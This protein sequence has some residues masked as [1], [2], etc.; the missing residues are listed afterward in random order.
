[1]KCASEFARTLL[2]NARSM[3]KKTTSLWDATAPAPR[4]E[5]VTAGVH[6]DVAIIGGG[7]TGLTAAILLKTRGKR[8]A[9]IE[10]G[11]IGAG[12]TGRTT[13]HL[14]EAIDRR[15]HSIART[16]SKDAARLVAE[17]S[18]ASIEHIASNIRE[19][20]IDC[21]FRRVPGFLYTE[22]RSYV[23]EVKQEARAA[24]EAGLR[25]KFV[26]EVPLPFPVRGAVL[27]EDQAQF[28]PGEYI[29]GLAARVPGDGS[30]IFDETHVVDITE[31]EPC[32]IETSGGK[33]TADS[34]FQA[35]NV[36][37]KGFTTL[38]TRDAAYRTYALAYRAS[39]N[40]PDGLFWDTADPYHYTRWQETDGGTF[41]I[42]GGAD[43]KTGHEHDTEKCYESVNQ[44]A[45]EHFGPGSIE[46]RWS[47]QVI[48][49]VDGLPFIG[50]SGKMFVST[51][52]SGQGMTFGTL[53]A[54]IVA[55]R[56]A[57]RANKFADLFDEK[58]IHVRG[59]LKEFV[60]ENVDFPARIV[61][62]RIAQRDVE[63][64]TTDA[65]KAGEGKILSVGGK[66]IAAYRD[67]SGR[68]S[69]ISPVCTHMKCDVAW[70]SAERSWDCP[71]HGSRFGVDGRVLNGPARDPLEKIELPKD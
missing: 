53:G 29:R 12:E 39:G 9:V 44:F 13:A 22:K 31:G 47:G 21:R 42:V 24:A 49:P 52:Y 36:P 1:M 48:E 71:C 62:D 50:G 16:F 14:T 3:N 17:A 4:F 54:M 60:T 20:A 11:H 41:M 5:S 26:S 2:A 38:H 40:H 69:C 32:V 35:T 46:Y 23:A 34:V 18:R 55:D 10:N 25:A 51:G 15:Y 65:V 59:A 27:F 43:H 58:R 19:L 33:V 63:G 57:G 67:Q 68:L 8:V 45:I 61:S 37:I 56:I 66:K 28:H 30:H 7:I 70:N 6:V 64:K